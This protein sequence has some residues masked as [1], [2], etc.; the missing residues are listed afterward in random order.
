MAPIFAQTRE[1]DEIGADAFFRH[2]A[3]A[4]MRTHP[5]GVARAALV[6][7]G[8]SLASVHPNVPLT[9]PRNIAAVL[10]NALLLVLA[11]VGVR[12]SRRAPIVIMCLVTLALLAIGPAGMR[13]WL[14]LRG[15][16]WILAGIAVMSMMRRPAWDTAQPGPVQPTRY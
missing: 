8:V 10:D 11:I 13:Y 2:A 6:K 16:L 14:T 3:V 7:I 9:A 1:L 4:Y 15:A 5:L 12:Y